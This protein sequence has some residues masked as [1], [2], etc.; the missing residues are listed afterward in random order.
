MISFVDRLRKNKVLV[1]GVCIVAALATLYGPKLVSAGRDGT[2]WRAVFYENFTGAAGGSVDTDDWRY[3]TGQGKFGNGEIETMTSS[4]LNVSL[5]GRGNL[6]IRA[7]DQNGTWTSARIE[8]ATLYG[9]PPGGEMKVVASIR[10]P[11]PANGLGYW[12]AFWL[13]GQGSWPK[14]GEIDIL[15]DVNGL[16]LHSGALHCGNLTQPNSDGTFGP[17]HEHTGL[18]SGMLPCASCQ[19]EFHAYSVIVDRRKAGREAITW[20]LDGHQYFRITERQLSARIWRAAVDHG[21]SIIFDVAI[22]GSYP[23]GRCGCVTPTS[24]TTSGGSMSVHNVAVYER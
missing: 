9:A 8:S 6:R 3:N 24:Q 21:F 1:G 16:S 4:P 19:R 10:Q 12:P 15:E 23:D 11:S 22:G 18:S 13:L 14:H 5:D 2:G 7:L 20:Y 17:C